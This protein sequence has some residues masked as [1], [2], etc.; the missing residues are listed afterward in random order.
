MQLPR[1]L[2]FVAPVVPFVAFG[3]SLTAQTL[4]ARAPG[5][6]LGFS[7]ER[8]ARIDSFYQRA[9]DRGQITGAVVLVLRD[10]KTAYERAFGWA[11]RDANRRMTPD[12]IFRIASQ[13]KAITSVAVLALAEEGKLGLGDPVSRFIPAFAKTSVAVH[14]ESGD[15]VVPAS[16]A[17]TIRD[18]LTHTA[19]ISYGTDKQVASL[20]EAKGLGPAA[21]YGWYTADKNE[22]ICT[23]MERVAALPFV[24]QPGERWVYGYNTDILGCVV[25]RASGMPLDQFI[26][27]RITAPLKMPDTH[28][29]LPTE[30]RDRLATVYMRSAE[31]T[32]VRSPN[33]ARGQGD[34]VDGPRQSFSGG[35]G[36]LSTARDYSRFL[37]MLLNKGELEGARVL[38]PKTVELMTSNQTG[39]LFSQNGEGFS[40]GFYT[41]ERP[42]ASGRLES[43]GSFGWGGAYGST[44]LVDPRERLVLVYMIQELPG[45]S[46]AG[47]YL[48]MLV[49]QALEESRSR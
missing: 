39:T 22:P 47:Q 25:E 46:D 8:L 41:V 34:Y 1:T 27:T 20:Y 45:M 32:T 10:G 35:A 14:T 30:K 36:L 5:S 11:D 38:G 9:V 4:P 7:A 48:P 28:F 18:L 19:G 23:T 29:F 17:I 31:G 26:R 42:G 24:A 49:Y 37:Q 21:G 3:T 33:G 6:R 2:R 40:L 43:V 15:S 44:Y 13:S 12:I 16:R